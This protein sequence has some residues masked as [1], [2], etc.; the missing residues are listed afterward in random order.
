MKYVK[1]F[2]VKFNEWNRKIFPFINYALKV[3]KK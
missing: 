3:S 1:I 2:E